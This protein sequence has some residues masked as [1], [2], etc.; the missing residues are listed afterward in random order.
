MSVV[1]VRMIG[2]FIDRFIFIAEWGAT[3]RS[4]ILEALSESQIARE[5]FLGVVLNKADPTAL[6]RI[7]AYKGKRFTDYYEG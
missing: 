5:R 1:D 3:K 4:L 6:G 7:E 2:R